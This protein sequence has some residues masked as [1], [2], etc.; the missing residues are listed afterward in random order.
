MRSTESTSHP[1]ILKTSRGSLKGL[2]QRDLVGNP[3][4]Y[5][6]TRVPYALPPTGSRRWRR[7]QALPEDFT[8]NDPQ[9]TPGDYTRFGPI[10]PQPHYDHGSIAVANP[11]AAPP[12]DNVQDE[13]CLYLNIWVP[14]SPAPNEKGWPVQFHIH[15]GWLQVGDA[16]QQNDTDPFDLMAHTTP[17]IIVSPTY[18][19]N[20]FGFLAGSELASLKEDASPSNY[21]L[22]DQRCALEWVAKNIHLFGGDASNI[23]VG[24]LSAGANSTFFQLNYDTLLPREKRLVR[25]VY[26]WSNAVAIQPNPTTS[27]VLTQQFNDLCAIFGIPLSS[28]P[29]EKLERLRQ[30]PAKD[31]IAS[32]AKMKMHTFRAST[33][34]CFI[35]STFLSSL[36]SGSFATR[37]AENDI[38]IFLG[39]VC[40]EKELY[41][42]V[43]PPSSYQGL[44]TQLANYYPA[45]VVK[46]LLPLYSMPASTST[47]AAEWAEVFSQ[48][49]A[50]AQV[51]AS[52]RGLTHIVLNPPSQKAGAAVKPLPR[53]NLH[54]YRISWRAK[55][56]DN[57]ISPAVGVCHGLD[58]PIWWASGWRADYTA[59]DKRV[60]QRFLEPFGRFLAGEKLHDAGAAAARG[61][62]SLRWLDHEGNVVEDKEDDLWDRGMRIWDTVWESQRGLVVKEKEG[63]ESRL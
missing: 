18:R 17:R 27:P 14:A 57:W 31:L 52:L 32:L 21:G 51:H 4:L 20:L 25:R 60:I 11:N 19:L 16:L 28:S 63:G 23:T 47:N 30:I 58:T 61:E 24:G 29:R 45:H 41:K 37:L 34:N 62:R 43:N 50:D 55:N 3:I 5:R 42:I 35:P 13:D 10:C 49:V 7:P 56:L 2:E 15:G 39:E 48:I 9:G 54:R 12:V 46:A 26:L 1:Y 44:V 8:F 22:W 36:H 53:A 33:D 40:D 6:F 38:S 59:Q